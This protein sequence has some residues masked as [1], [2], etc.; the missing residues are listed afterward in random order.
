MV[1]DNAIGSRFDKPLLV[2]MLKIFSNMGLGGHTCSHIAGERARAKLAV[3]IHLRKDFCNIPCPATEGKHV[4]E[5]DH[6][7]KKGHC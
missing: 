3:D 4:W 5:S 2:D 1:Q 7:M 6:I